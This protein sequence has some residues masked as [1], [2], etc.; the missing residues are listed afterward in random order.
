M[1]SHISAEQ[2]WPAKSYVQISG[3]RPG[4]LRRRGA[5]TPN[6][7]NHLDIVVSAMFCR[8]DFARDVAVDARS[9]IA[10]MKQMLQMYMRQSNRRANERDYI[11]AASASY[12]ECQKTVLRHYPRRKNVSLEAPHA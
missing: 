7:R 11:H 6:F 5:S 2:L 9:L 8:E 3:N 4:A 12:D 1:N 10:A